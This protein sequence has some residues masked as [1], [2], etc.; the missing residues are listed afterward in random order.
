VLEYVI[1]GKLNKQIAGALGTVEQT[2]KAHRAHVM[3]KMR[4]HSVAE[5]VRLTERC[6]IDGKTR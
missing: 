2:I 1:A 3:E 4:V 5:L 6:G